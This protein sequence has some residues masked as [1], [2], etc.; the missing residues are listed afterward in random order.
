MDVREFHLGDILT[1]THD[2]LLAPDGMEGIYD[3]LEFLTGE[4]LY[5]H[6][7]PRVADECRPWLLEQFPELDDVEI[8]EFENDAHAKLWRS[9]QIQQYGKTFLVA[10]MPDE[11]HEQRD[12]LAEL[13]EMIDPNEQTILPIQLRDRPDSD[14]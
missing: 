6:Q 8:P 11:R 10:E 13:H 1:I 5:T 12:P 14:S 9:R 3:I 2:R 4:S 7:L